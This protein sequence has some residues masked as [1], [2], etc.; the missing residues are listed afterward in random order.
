MNIEIL[1]IVNTYLSKNEVMISDNVDIDE[2][3][4]LLAKYID[5]LIYNVVS[6]VALI[7]NIED[8]EKIQPKHLVAA[9]AYIAH[10]CVGQSASKR[11]IGGSH[12]I[13]LEE[14]NKINPPTIDENT[15]NNK[16]KLCYNMDMR[17]FVHQVLKH[18][19]M[20]ISKGAI[21][22]ILMILNE[23]MQCL[24]NDIKRQEP[25]TIGKLEKIMIMKRYSIFH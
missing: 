12:K 24:L 3:V 22:G 11:I 1:P 6:V 2:L 16:Y 5:A 23:H 9:Q 7:A 25:I 21:K 15:D 4:Y 14:L 8:K 17:S 18:H 20:H 10:K 19:K 13:T